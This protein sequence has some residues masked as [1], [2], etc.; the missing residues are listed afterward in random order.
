MTEL[1]RLETREQDGVLVAVLTGEVDLSN[2]VS[3]EERIAAA[4]G[5]VPLVVDLTAVTFIDSAGVRLLDH[6]VAARQPGLPIRVV[7]PPGSRV[8]FTLRLCG[9]RTELVAPDLEGGVT[10]LRG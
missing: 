10:D 2:A 9:F 4:A 5:D 6:L 8:L 7:A 1:A 3:L